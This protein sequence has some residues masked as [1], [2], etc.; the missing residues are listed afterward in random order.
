VE[1]EVLERLLAGRDP[2]KMTLE[3]VDHLPYLDFS[4]DHEFAYAQDEVWPRLLSVYFDEIIF[5][6]LIPEPIKADWAK[7]FST[8]SETPDYMLIYLGQKK[9]S[10]TTL[11]ELK[12]TVT[13]SRLS[14]CPLNLLADYR[15]SFDYVIRTLHVLKQIKERGI[16]GL[17]DIFAERLK[18][19]LDDKKRRYSGINDVLKLMTKIN[20]LERIKTFFNPDMIEGKQTKVL[21]H[22]AMLPLFGFRVREITGSETGLRPGPNSRTPPGPESLALLPFNEHGRDRGIHEDRDESGTGGRALSSL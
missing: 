7:R 18:Q 19:P 5:K 11:E 15:D 10:E 16:V 17:S 12:H 6:P 8:G 14:G 2:E 20:R 3:E 9:P 22:L 1:Q 21:K 4:L 13:D